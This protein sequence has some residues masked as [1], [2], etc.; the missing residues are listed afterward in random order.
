MKK[1][2]AMLAILAG[3]AFGAPSSALAAPL[4]TPYTGGNDT[5]NWPNGVYYQVC[6]TDVNANSASFVA[7]A[8]S[9]IPNPSTPGTAG[10]LL[11][12]S[13][14]DLYANG[15]VIN[16]VRMGA[17]RYGVVYIFH[18]WQEWQN[19]ATADEKDAA[20]ASAGAATITIG[21]TGQ[22]LYTAIW[23]VNGVGID[24]GWKGGKNIL[25]QEVG[26]EFGHWVDYLLGNALVGGHLLSDSLQFKNEWTK[27]GTNFIL[28]SI[29]MC[30]DLGF[31]PLA[32]GKA[33]GKATV[34]AGK[35]PYFICSGYDDQGT[36][37]FGAK[38]NGVGPH[39]NTGYSGSNYTVVQKAWVYFYTPGKKDPAHPYQEMFAEEFGTMFEGGDANRAPVQADTYYANGNATP[40]SF[41]CSYWFTNYVANNGKLPTAT[42]N[43][44]PPANKCP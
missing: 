16:G 41:A 24:N 39:L 12:N 42:N 1:L 11:K 25:A 31:N 23:E 37:V 32:Y 19:F 8:F 15:A 33:D 17:G 14:I 20:P 30:G 5:Q 34:K 10:A 38:S 36:E 13:M 22:A 35:P 2:L 44:Y 40:Q 27:D 43:Y 3:F 4:C 9:P 28:P 7:A 6:G 21:T 18:T 26:H 29:K